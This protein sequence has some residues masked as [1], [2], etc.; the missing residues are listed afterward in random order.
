MHY[1]SIE[2]IHKV[3]NPLF[4]DELN[5]EFAEI[6]ALPQNKNRDKKFAEF[7]NKIANLNFLDPACG[8]GNF[9]TETYISLRKLENEILYE[10]Q[11]GQDGIVDCRI[12]ND[13][14]N[15]RYC[16]YGFGFSAIKNLRK[17]S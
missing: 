4:M 13:E 3:I 16:P 17:Y 12:P 6:K 11:K 8:S 5:E 10:L 1:T 14:E 7:Q 2:N 9:L 15:G